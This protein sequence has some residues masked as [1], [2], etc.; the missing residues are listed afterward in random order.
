MPVQ[1]PDWEKVA[2]VLRSALVGGIATLVDLALLGTLVHAL[3][4][5]PELASAPALI[6]GVAAQFVGNKL[7]AFRDRRPHWLQQGALF[8]AVEALGFTLNLFVFHVAVTHTELPPL[9]LRLVITSS[10][11]F[12]VCLPLWKHIFKPTAGVTP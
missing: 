8:L 2:V 6:V 4:V 3:D 1:V 9:A 11:Y 5:R 12:G 10:V 7:F